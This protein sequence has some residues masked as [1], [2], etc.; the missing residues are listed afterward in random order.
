MDYR[1]RTSM[2]FDELWRVNVRSERG[3]D[4]STGAQETI[5]PQ[6]DVSEHLDELELT[7]ADLLF[8]REL[9]IKV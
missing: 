2:T 1:R 9:R 4:E 8:L 7:A 3:P 5:V 6:K